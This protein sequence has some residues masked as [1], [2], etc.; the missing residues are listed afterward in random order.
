MKR[1]FLATVAPMILAAVPVAAE[2]DGSMFHARMYGQAMLG[3]DLMDMPVYRGDDTG[4]TQSQGTVQDSWDEIGEVADFVLSP[5]GEVQA[6]VLDIGGFLGTGEHP[7]AVD[8]SALSFGQGDGD[9]G[10]AFVLVKTDRATL[11]Q[12]PAFEDWSGDDTDMTD[13]GDAG[14]GTVRNANP[15]DRVGNV[16][17]DTPEPTNDTAG[18]TGMTGQDTAATDR[19]DGATG[20][21]VMPGRDG[22]V[23]AQPQDLTAEALTGAPLYGSDDEDIGEVSE[24]L[25]AD[26]G[27]V[28]SVIVDVGG[29]L[30]LGE[31]PVEL[32]L[33]DL[34]I[35]REETGTSIVAYVSMTE[36]ELESMP[37]YRD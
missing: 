24:I 7:V 28:Q 26:D 3:S 37:E 17:T 22:Y 11:E 32:Q 27:K 8:M 33:E 29:F 21:G 36:E 20:T 2:D 31:K 4:T 12:A 9:G 23:A 16:A 18:R 35:L 1:L 5:E 19:T 25:L 34:D 30:G 6:V 14:T 15:A 13:A 10:D